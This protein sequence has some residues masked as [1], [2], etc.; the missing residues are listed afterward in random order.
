M[1]GSICPPV[2]FNPPLPEK[3]PRHIRLKARLVQVVPIVS[4]SDDSIQRGEEIE[5]YLAKMKD[6]DSRQWVTLQPP[7]KEVST[8]SIK[9][10]YLKKMP[11]EIKVAA[12]KELTEQEVANEREYRASIVF[13]IDGRNEHPV[14]HVLY[15]NPVFVSLPACRPTGKN[16]ALGELPRFLKNTW[17][18]ER[19]ND[20]TPL[21]QQGRVRKFLRGHG[22]PKGER[23]QL[24][25]E[26][27][28]RVLFALCGE[29]VRQG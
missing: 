8:I 19:L 27:A 28:G 9:G 3:R 13:S 6:T 11:L 14:T 24:S 20:H 23:M 10:I 2:E 29:Q 25:G 7:I 4:S 18:V 16:G 5:D 22:A 17:T 21:M 26:V 15:T 1:V 12:N